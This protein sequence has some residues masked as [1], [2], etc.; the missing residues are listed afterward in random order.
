MFMFSSFQHLH[1]ALEEHSV[2]T[3]E[4]MINGK[5]DIS[6]STFAKSYVKDAR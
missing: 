5:E 4:E 2:A 3:P 1:T 6:K